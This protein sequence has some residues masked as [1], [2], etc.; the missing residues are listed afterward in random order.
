MME[1]GDRTHGVLTP[2]LRGRTNHST[3]NK[4]LTPVPFKSKFPTLTGEGSD[5][6]FDKSRETQVLCMP[7]PRRVGRTLAGETQLNPALAGSLC[8]CLFF[9]RACR[10]L[11]SMYFA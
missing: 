2:R 6:L 5:H 3:K 11:L 1:A 10:V 7:F 4:G 9:L 8:D